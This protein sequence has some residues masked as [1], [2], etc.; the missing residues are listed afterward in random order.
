MGI[1]VIFEN[2]DYIFVNKPSGM[3]TILDRHDPTLPSA[4]ALLRKKFPDVFTVHRID[5]DTSGCVVFAKHASAHRHASMA[6]ENRNV[7]KKYLGLT[8]GTLPNVNGT[9][10]DK[11]MDHPVI[12]GKM[13]VNAKLG[14]ETITNYTELENFK[15]YSLVE[16]HILTG[17]M[18]QIRIHSANMGNPLLCDPI[19]G[20]DTPILVSMFKRKKFKLSKDAE[21][22]RPILNRLALHSHTI[23]FEDEQGKIVAANAPL[24]KDMAATLQQLR[25]WER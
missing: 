25:K 3:L 15:G 14:K 8:L 11:I 19:Y 12:K 2:D 9:I 23:E 5:R 20:Q 22:E 17:R 10:T 6:F 4:I 21:E 7:T 24:F 16:Y 13:I 18:H 1:D